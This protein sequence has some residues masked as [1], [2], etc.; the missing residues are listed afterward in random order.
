MR[1]LAYILL[2]LLLVAGAGGVLMKRQLRLADDD[3]SAA[4]PAA[5]TRSI[6]RESGGDKAVAARPQRRIDRGIEQYRTP[7][8]GWKLFE[9]VIDVLNVV[10]GI[11]G[12]GLAV[13]GM[14]MRRDEAPRGRDA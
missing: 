4:A 8:G 2:G 14:R 7:Q 3:R 12:I 13:S 1:N 5:A 9:A 6:A 11:V 10:V